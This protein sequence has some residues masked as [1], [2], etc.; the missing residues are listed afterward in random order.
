MAESFEKAFALVADTVP[1]HFTRCHNFIIK[2]GANPDFFQALLVFLGAFTGI[3]QDND[4]FF[5]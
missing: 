3:R 2:G 4:L 5:P 1:R